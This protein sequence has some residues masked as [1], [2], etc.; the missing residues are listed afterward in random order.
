MSASLTPRRAVAAFLAAGA[1]VGAAAL[2][3]SASGDHHRATHSSVVI[4]S[5]QHET[6]S[7]SVSNHALNREWVEVKNTGRHG[8]DLRGYT[9]TD[10]QGNRYRFGGLRLASGHSVKVH[11]GQGHNTRSDVYQ[12]RRQQIWDARDTATLRDDRGRVID[13]ESWGGRQ[14]SRHHG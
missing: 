2:P 9:L 3:A 6:H 12:N 14:G 4:G 8:V 7:R 5:V 13:T 11:T 10:R 1:L